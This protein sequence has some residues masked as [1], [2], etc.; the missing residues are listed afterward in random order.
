MDRMEA[1]RRAAWF[2]S[3]LAAAIL[4]SA[5][6]SLAAVAGERGPSGAPLAPTADP[7]ALARSIAQPWPDLQLPSGAYRDYVRG[8]GTGMRFSESVLGYGLLLQGLQAGDRRIVDSGLRAL[9]L[10]VA[11]PRRL[12][13]YPSVFENFA[14]AASYNLAVRR[15][16]DNP[17]FAGF[18]QKWETWLRN[19]RSL[20]MS[21]VDVVANKQLVE[22][23]SMLELLR[24]G[25]QSSDPRTVVGNRSASRR[26]AQDFVNRRVP[27]LTA[28]GAV[29]VD[30]ERTLVFSDPRSE[31][32]AYHALSMGFFAR[33]VDLMGTR[34][35]AAPRRVLREAARASWRLASPSGD[36]S[37]VGRSQEQAWTLPF[38]A[39]GAAT[40]AALPG[41]TVTERPRLDA[42]IERVLQR[43]RTRYAAGPEGLWI[44]PALA[45]EKEGGLRGL[46]YYAG[47]AAYTGLTLVALDWAATRLRG[48]PL[49]QGRLAADVPGAARLSLGEGSCV[50]VRT[51]TTWFAVKQ[52]PS[53]AEYPGDLRYDFG[54]ATLDRR[55]GD[56]WTTVVPLR[57]HTRGATHE[58]AGPILLSGGRRGLPYG[59]RMSATTD[60]VVRIQGGFRAA[61]GAWLRRGVVFRFQPDGDGVRLSF[62]ARGGDRFEYSGF[63][64][65][66]GPAPASDGRNVADARERIAF[67]GPQAMGAPQSGYSSGADPRLVRTRSLL[68][69]P[70]S[71]TVSVWSGPA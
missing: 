29:A 33:A 38:T 13:T 39:Y 34:A 55:V 47:A 11:D 52:A 63:F 35:T 7:D 9:D 58:S 68:T 10:V 24:T 25:V 40:A 6:P 14:V 53:F 70:T 21:R 48:R 17:L 69:A 42:L 20:R 8:E 71:G 61:N 16:K 50:V 56:E 19:V 65:E 12:I 32:L 22:V 60:G 57:P 3:L 46:D 62:T 27:R 37:Y 18:R 28:R 54:L 36:V 43:L 2:P 66:S 5:A 4:I 45:L 51:P 15:A 64:L 41:A 44:T 49:N 26:L 1:V 59:T 31:P 23:V 67:S 30:G